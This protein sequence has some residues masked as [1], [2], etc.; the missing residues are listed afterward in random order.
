MQ[1]I[2]IWGHWGGPNPWYVCGMPDTCAIL[3]SSRK[4]RM[5]LEELGLPFDWKVLELDQ[6]KSEA[7]VA[8]NPNG[9]LPTIEDPNTGIILWEVGKTPI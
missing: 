6:A 7:Y 1:A 2:K 4:V 5:V 9:R 8:L 3:I